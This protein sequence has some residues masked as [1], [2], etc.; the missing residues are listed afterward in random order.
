MPPQS[1]GGTFYLAL[2]E[3]C[4]QLFGSMTEY[5]PENLKYNNLK[6]HIKYRT[7]DSLRV[8]Q[9]RQDIESFVRNSIYEKYPH[10]EQFYGQ[11]DKIV[12]SER[13]S[14]NLWGKLIRVGNA[15]YPCQ[16]YAKQG[17]EKESG[18]L[19]MINGSNY[20]VTAVESEFYPEAIFQKVTQ[21]TTKTHKKHHK[22]E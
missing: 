2:Q 17:S 13:F 7:Q 12:D 3:I 22:T 1:S 11:Q 14:A 9:V 10:H 19:V 21:N 20:Y 15:V 16:E 4:R 6:F 18:E 5:I 8:S